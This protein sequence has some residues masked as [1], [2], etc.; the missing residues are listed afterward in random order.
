MAKCEFL[1]RAE[2]ELHSNAHH[3]KLTNHLFDDP[4]N[5]SATFV[6]VVSK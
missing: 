3:S 6:A 5:A 4:L 1:A 2:E